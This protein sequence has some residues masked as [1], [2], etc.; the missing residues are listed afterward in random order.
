[1]LVPR[2]FTKNNMG[3]LSNLAGQGATL[4]KTEFAQF[5][6]VIP[7]SMKLTTTRRG[8]A[9]R[10]VPVKIRSEQQQ[11]SSNGNKLIR[12]MLPND[13][14][15]DTRKGFLSFQVAL[16]TT[17]GT[18]R[19]IHSGIFSIIQRLRILANSTEIEDQRDY[20]RTYAAIWEMTQPIQVTSNIGVPTMGFGSQATRNGLFPSSGSVYSF[21]CPLLSGVLNTE[22]LPMDNIQ[23]GV[24]LELYLDDAVNCVETDGTVP[25]ITVS[26]PEFHMERL[27]VDPSYRAFLRNKVATQGLNIGFR[28]WNRF[29]NALNT[30]SLQNI[31]INTRNASM[32]GMINFL[33]N[34]ATISDPTVNDKFITWLPTPTGGTGTLLSSQLKINGRTFPDEPVNTFDRNRYDAYQMYCRWV[35]RWNLNGILAIAP[36]INSQAYATTRFVQIDDLEAYPEEPDLVNPSSTMN[37][38]NTLIKIYNFSGTIGAN[39]QLDTYV[40]SF[41]FVT[42]G[43]SGI[44]VLA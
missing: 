30:G 14:L 12:F 6:D 40:E 13:S 1:M 38:N 26:N 25:I 19:R 7:E 24:V 3:D 20:N 27:E 10:R 16:Q 8:M 4:S 22:L 5:T 15:Y 11:Y 23:A 2:V 17:G 41:Q 21:V 39:Y 44:S 28:I 33:I 42:I 32:N 43:S 35:M 31:T 37:I 34:S 36:P 29:T 18:Y 9:C